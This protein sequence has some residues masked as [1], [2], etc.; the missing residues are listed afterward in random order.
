MTSST[1]SPSMLLCAAGLPEQ[2]VDQWS[3]AV[4][5]ETG[6]Y[7][8]DTQR[9]GSFWSQSARLLQRCRSSP[10]ETRPNGRPRTRYCLIRARRVSPFSHRTPS[11][12]MAC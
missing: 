7:Q 11:R 6:D 4:P 2:A 9:Y 10:S 8:S 3:R 12:C 5:T 1:A